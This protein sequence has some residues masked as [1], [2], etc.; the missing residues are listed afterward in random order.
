M[1]TVENDMNGFKYDYDY[2]WFLGR[3]TWD[4]WVSWVLTLSVIEYEYNSF[5]AF[6]VSLA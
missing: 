1:K 6:V 5:Y 3:G 4:T 2:Y